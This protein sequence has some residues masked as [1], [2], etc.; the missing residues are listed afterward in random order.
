MN[1]CPCLL[2]LGNENMI[3]VRIL[4][5]QKDKISKT[6]MFGFLIC[7]GYHPVNSYKKHRKKASIIV[8]PS[9]IILKNVGTDSVFRLA[10]G[11]V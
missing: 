1:R 8:P 2:G 11:D 5:H 7:G 9:F 6:S 3:G 10:L 4:T